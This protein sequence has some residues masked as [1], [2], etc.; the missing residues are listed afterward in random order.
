MEHETQTEEDEIDWRAKYNKAM[1]ELEI[2]R[3]EV[4]V[5]KNNLT[6]STKL[7]RQAQVDLE[8]AVEL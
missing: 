2:Q 1:A 7:L 4:E 5:Q 8:A 3:T 6:S